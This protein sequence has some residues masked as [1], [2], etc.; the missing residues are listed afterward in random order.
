MLVL[1]YAPDNASLIV[2]LALEVAGASFRT[3]RVERPAALDSA[4]YRALNPAGRIPALETPDGAMFETAAILLWLA[5][6]HPD[7]GLAPLPGQPGRAAFLSWLFFLSNTPHADLRHLFYPDRH[8]SPE[9]QA[10]HRALTIARMKDHF[11][12]VDR[13]AR[14][15]PAL[16]ALP[17]ALTLYACTLV[18]WAVLY[19]AGQDPWCEPAAYPAL[20]ALSKALDMHPAAVKAA[21]DEGLGPNPFSVPIP[22]AL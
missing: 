21:Q 4:A 17:S 9:G 12:I 2:R 6:R 18:R 14:D 11:R 5:E 15:R 22:L 10:G 19:P 7:A 1:H 20:Y 13:A 8:A 16:F 3:V